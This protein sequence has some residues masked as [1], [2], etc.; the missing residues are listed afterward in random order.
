MNHDGRGP[1]TGQ[2]NPDQGHS[3]LP[4]PLRTFNYLFFG[5]VFLVGVLGWIATSGR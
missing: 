1:D 5:V 2:E 3:M 4:K